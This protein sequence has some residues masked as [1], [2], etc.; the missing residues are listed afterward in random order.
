MK[1]QQVKYIFTWEELKEI[2]K[3]SN[4]LFGCTWPVHKK[5]KR[6]TQFAPLTDSGLHKLEHRPGVSKN[7][8]RIMY[9]T[10][11]DFLDAYVK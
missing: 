11:E 6:S 2:Q 10:D 3:V 9:C 1:I 4:W 8:C 5:E 7:L